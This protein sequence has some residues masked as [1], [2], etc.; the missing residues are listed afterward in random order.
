MN[1]FLIGIVT[2]QEDKNNSITYRSVLRHTNRDY[3]IKVTTNNTR[4]LTTTYNEML[5]HAVRRNHKQLFLMHDDIELRQNLTEFDFN[6]FTVAGLAGANNVTIKS[7]FMWHLTSPRE[8]QLGAVAHGD[9]KNYMITSF[10]RFNQRAV[11]VDGVFIAID[12]V[13][14]KENPVYFDENIPTGFHFYD[15]CFSLDCNL[16]KV[17]V[18]VVDF[19]ITHK[20]PGLNK[21]FDVWKMGEDYCLTKYSKY[22]N[23]TLLA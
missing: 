18:G 5:E 3:D 19:P 6:G 4:K 21:G 13:K 8:N 7:P 15:L 10:G 1:P 11:L 12:M 23:K 2:P 22:L 9:N 14:W 17:S 20:S 16:K